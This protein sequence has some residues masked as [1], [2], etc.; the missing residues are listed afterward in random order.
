MTDVVPPC[1]VETSLKK[2][3]KKKHY[4]DLLYLLWVFTVLCVNIVNLDFLLSSLA[5]CMP[6]NLVLNPNNSSSVSVSWT[7]SNRA[8]T[9][10]VSAVG[11]DGIRT[12]TTSGNSCDITGLP[13]GSVYE[14]SV[15]A[16]SAAGLSL[17]SYTDSLETGE[18]WKMRFEIIGT[19][20]KHG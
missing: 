8:A 13:C 6:M 9:Y 4:E 16:A 12:C 20:K 11:D 15:T 7:A 10:T 2:T 5:P 1:I 3:N 18:Q 17:P 14:V 19:V